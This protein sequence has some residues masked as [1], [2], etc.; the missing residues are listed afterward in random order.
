MNPLKRKASFA[1]EQRATSVLKSRQWPAKESS[2]PD[3]FLIP[4][5]HDETA[6]QRS[7]GVSESHLWTQSRNPSTA[8]QEEA[9][10]GNDTVMEQ[11]I[12]ESEQIGDD[13]N[14][15]GE[16]SSDPEHEDDVN[17]ADVASQL[18]QELEVAA[19][20]DTHV[21]CSAVTFYRTK[22]DGWTVAYRCFAFSASRGFL[23]CRHS[24]S[25][26]SKW[27]D[28]LSRA[29]RWLEGDANMTF[30]YAQLLHRGLPTTKFKEVAKWRLKSRTQVSMRALAGLNMIKT[31]LFLCL[32]HNIKDMKSGK[33]GVSPK[34]VPFPRG[35]GTEIQPW[36]VEEPARSR[37][38]TSPYE[39]IMQATKRNLALSDIY[40]TYVLLSDA[41]GT[42]TELGELLISSDLKSLFGRFRSG[43]Q[44]HGLF[45]TN[46]IPPHTSTRPVQ[47]QVAVQHPGGAWHFDIVNHEGSSATVEGLMF[48]EHGLV[49]LDSRC[50][51]SESGVTL[52]SP[53]FGVKASQECEDMDALRDSWFAVH[54]SVCDCTAS[55][56]RPDGDINPR[57]HSAWKSIDV[58]EQDT[59]WDQG[60]IDGL[61]D[62][63]RSVSTDGLKAAS[64]V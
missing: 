39:L 37:C 60:Y 9:T 30:Y 7:T 16:F 27:Q 42:P 6:P 17:D 4:P 35:E 23:I 51:S 13:D 45:R 55:A 58:N 53:I 49:I 50:I 31:K 41:H 28:P 26:T 38:E 61:I 20:M 46:R 64:G 1:F 29:S 14:H 59:N 10:Q 56:P 63:L 25:T 62:Q 15:D 8:T 21:D 2:G 44:F 11:S 34:K 36:M 22:K 52:N 5:P 18:I 3:P 24:K 12:R 32:S 54:D 48:L 47:C 19:A 33:L 40:G 43:D 57:L